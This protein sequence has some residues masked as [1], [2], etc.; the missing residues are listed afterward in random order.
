MRSV[1][2]NGRAATKV[3]QRMQLKLLTEQAGSLVGSGRQI[4]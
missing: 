4:G 2:S 1:I 3:K